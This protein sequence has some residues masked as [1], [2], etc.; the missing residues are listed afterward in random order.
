M[1]YH[2]RDSELQALKTMLQGGAN[3]DLS[4]SGC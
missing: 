2:R 1:G 4:E 3:V